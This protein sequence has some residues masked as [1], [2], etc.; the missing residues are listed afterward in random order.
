M[1]YK[2]YEIR[3]GR[4]LSEM[5]ESEQAYIH[6]EWDR[7]CERGSVNTPE[8][9][10]S[11]KAN[12]FFIKATRERIAAARYCGSAGGFWSVRL[13]NCRKWGFKKN[14][15]GQFDPEPMEKYFSGLTLQTGETVMVPKTVHTKKEVLE[16]VKK[17]G[18]EL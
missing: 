10:F 1:S 8:L 9:V 13:G 2:H 5:T 18:F 4:K 7:L 16:L 11:Q 12:G 14:P 17:L 3:D 6:K 15:F